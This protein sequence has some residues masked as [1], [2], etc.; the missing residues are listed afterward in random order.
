M[1]PD[2]RAA[3]E[4]AAER[5]PA[6]KGEPECGNMRAKRIIGAFGILQQI[7]ANLRHALILM[8]APEGEGPAIEGPEID[9]GQI[10]GRTIAAE[11]VAFVDNRP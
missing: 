2:K 7:G 5:G 11:H 10:I 4:L 3:R 9:R 6:R 8:L 1:Q